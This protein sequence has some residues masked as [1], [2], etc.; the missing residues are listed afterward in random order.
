MLFWCLGL[1]FFIAL[2]TENDIA[3]G[4]LRA[5][6]FKYGPFRREDNMEHKIYQLKV[7]VPETVME[8]IW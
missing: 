5:C 6:L 7:T 1:H 2:K 4:S 8:T 3:K